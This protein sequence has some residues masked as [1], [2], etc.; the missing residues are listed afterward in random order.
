ML[1]RDGGELS[2]VR[3]CELLDLPRSSIYYQP[4]AASEEDLHLMKLL[5]EQYLLRPFYGSRRMCEWLQ[6]QGYR[7][8]R[9]RIQRLMRKMGI[10]ALYPKP[11]THRGLTPQG[12]FL[13]GA[14]CRK[15]SV[16]GSQDMAVLT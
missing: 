16:K 14:A 15:L 1:E 6:Q 4:V 13:Q 7:V 5:D 10:E 11:S 3:Q 8:N 2:V 12:C 9:K